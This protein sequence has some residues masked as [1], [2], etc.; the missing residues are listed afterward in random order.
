LLVA[1]RS[2]RANNAAYDF[3]SCPRALYGDEQPGLLPEPLPPD[4]DYPMDSV[5]G[6]QGRIT[7]LRVHELGTGYGPPSDHIDAEVIVWLDAEP[8]KAFGFQLRDDECRRA[9]KGMLA[10][11]RDAFNHDRPVRI[12]FIRSGCRTGRIIRVIAR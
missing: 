8:E 11:L 6:A 7:L 1:R 3:V 10:V 5:Q 12:D 4:W 9:A 2:P